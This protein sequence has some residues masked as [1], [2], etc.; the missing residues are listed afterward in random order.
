VVFLFVEQRGE[1]AALEVL[2]DDHHSHIVH[3]VAVEYFD[4]VGVVECLQVLRLLEDHVDIG[5]G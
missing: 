2:H 5:T 4:D 1:L 3:G